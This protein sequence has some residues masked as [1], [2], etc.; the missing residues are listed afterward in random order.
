M[1]LGG[2]APAQEKPVV[3]VD[4][5]SEARFPDGTSWDTAVITIR[6]GIR[7]AELLGGAEVW[8][9][10]GEYSEVIALLE[11][12]DIYGGFLGTEGMRDERDFARNITLING[13][14]A[15]SGAPAPTIVFGANGSTLD[16]FTISGG[17]GA[18]GAAMLNDNASPVV[19]N[20]RFA[21]NT[22]QGSGGAI[23]NNPGSSPVIENCEF[24]GNFAGLSG[25]AIANNGAA[26]EIRD[27]LFWGN[28]TDGAGGA[29]A[30]TPGAPALIERCT[31]RQNNAVSG[32]AIHN[33]EAAATIAGCQF[34]DNEAA[35]FGGAVFNDAAD[36]AYVNCLFTRNHAA[37]YG[38]AM[39]NLDAGTRV[40]NST[41][42]DNTAQQFGGAVFNSKSSFHALNTIFWENAPEDVAGA[43]STVR[44]RY[45]LVRGGFSGT[46]N[47]SADPRFRAPES[48]DY[49]LAPDSPCID[50]G[51]GNGAPDVDIEGTARPQ[52]ARVDMGAF[53]ATEIGDPLLPGCQ[54]RF[55]KN[56]VAHPHSGN[57][58]LFAGVAVF[59]AWP[60]RRH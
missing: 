39:A 36:P 11:G 19:R 25:G 35:A 30:N 52:G 8:V 48:G 3:H 56:T 23:L 16:G 12:V 32:G 24:L 29:I 49:S 43:S 59:L 42:A 40:V 13:A 18:Y 51:T 17:E 2:P 53:E 38:G 55:V 20:C 50:R 27:C 37:Q 31:F 45:S 46:G 44:L 14:T 21:N 7:R 1:W 60:R 33:Q 28:G 5:R 4:W 15:N 41:F 26:P 58:V 47:L 22:V 57:V 54:V 34:E 6:Q 10:A 9:A